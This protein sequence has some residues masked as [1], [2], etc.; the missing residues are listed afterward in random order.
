LPVYRLREE[1]RVREDLSWVPPGV[2]TGKASIARVYDYIL[3]GT[4][5]VPADREAAR[6]L[7]AVQPDVPGIARANREFLARAV[8]FLAAAGIRQ[9]LDIGSGIPTRGNV[10]EIAQQAAPGSRVAYVDIDPVAVAHS[11]SIL[12]GQPG[13]GVV[14]ADLRQPE[15]ILAS[16][17]VRRLIDFGRPVGLLLGSVLH[18]LPDAEEPWRLVGTL[19]D[20]LAPGSYLVISH[21]TSE[22]LPDADQAAIAEAYQTRVETEGGLRS[23]AGVG[24]FFDGFR[25]VDPG[26]VLITEWRPDAPA[27]G[28]AGP[29]HF[30]F[31]AGVG[32]KP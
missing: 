27:A 8:R 28:A 9:F 15:A 3:G 4:H 18:F 16:A 19:R 26:L 10:H 24:R 25:L 30:W 12:A 2:D 31:I 1:K 23:R 20:A 7:I 14:Q 32:L 21:A 22:G 6:A 17:D 11:R 13:A 29:V 5:N